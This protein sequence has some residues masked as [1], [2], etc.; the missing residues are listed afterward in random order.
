MKALCNMHFLLQGFL[1]Y[2]LCIQWWYA[3]K[4]YLGMLCYH[5]DM[6]CITVLITQLFETDT[7]YVIWAQLNQV[8]FNL[9]PEIKKQTNKQT[10]NKTKI[11]KNK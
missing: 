4:V 8:S 1:V 5:H 2:L 6:T 3:N 9:L 7:Y 11:N 10:K